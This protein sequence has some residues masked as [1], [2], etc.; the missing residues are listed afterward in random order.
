MNK[1]KQIQK[2]QQKHPT[3]TN[4][5]WKIQLN[6]GANGNGKAK[7]ASPSYF[8][9]PLNNIMCFYFNLIGSRV[10]FSSRY[11]SGSS[12]LHMHFGSCLFFFFSSSFGFVKWMNSVHVRHA[13]SWPDSR[14]WHLLRTSIMFRSFSF[15]YR[16]FFFIYT[17]C[18]YEIYLLR[19]GARW[20]SF[21]WHIVF[22]SYLICSS[23]KTFGFSFSFFLIK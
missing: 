12:D 18:S 15:Y 7:W 8:C 11:C 2:Q 22:S 20:H 1:A 19:K 3:T 23:I 13:H 21:T 5:A 14:I 16:K 9:L 4:C 10:L 17:N 6:S